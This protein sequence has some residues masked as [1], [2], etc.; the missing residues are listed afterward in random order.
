MNRSRSLFTDN[1]LVGQS[2]F[3]TSEAETIKRSFSFV[4]NVESTF[5]RDMLVFRK[6]HHLN[7]DFAK[8]LCIYI[9]CIAID[10][11]T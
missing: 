9:N 6:F 5:S 10:N 1:T 7:I 4:P 11:A 3:R 8:P 2:C